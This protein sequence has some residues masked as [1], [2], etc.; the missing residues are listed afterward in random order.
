MN[1]P[2]IFLN[3]KLFAIIK[4]CNTITFTFEKCGNS[5][6][7][8]YVQIQIYVNYINPYTLLTFI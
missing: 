5:K 3:V 7:Q 8:E 2:Y 4:Y 6:Q 1:L